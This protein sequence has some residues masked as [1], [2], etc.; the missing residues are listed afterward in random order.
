MYAEGVPVAAKAAPGGGKLRSVPWPQ[1]VGRGRSSAAGAE[2][3]AALY[4]RES[5]L[6]PLGA[7]GAAG[8]P[9]G[10]C[11]RAG[12]EGAAPLGSCGPAPAPV[13]PLRHP[14][15]R[16][17]PVAPLG[18]RGSAMATAALLGPVLF[19][20]FTCI[21]TVQTTDCLHLREQC[22]NA[23]N[24]CESVWNVVEDACNISVLGN[25]CKAEDSVGCNRIIHVLADEYP[26]FRNCVCTTDDICSITTLLGELCSINKDYLESPSGSDPELGVRPPRSPADPGSCSVARRLCREQPRCWAAHRS[27]QRHCRAPAGTCSSPRPASCLLAWK[28]LSTTPLGRCTCP[29]PRRAR[30][31]TIW[32]GIFNNPCLQHSQESQASGAGDSDGSDD[33]DN[34]DLDGEKNLVTDTNNISME[35]KLQWGLSALSKQAHTTNRTCLDVNR[36]CVEDEVCNKQLSL[37]LK[38]C[39]VNKK[40]NVEGCQAAIRFF[41]GNMP[42]EVAQM[43]IFCDC[44]QHDESCYRAKELLH[45]K[46]CAVTVVPP[47]SCLNVIQMC[48]ENELCRKKYTTFRSKC[49]RHVTKKCYND[50]ACLE[51]LLKDDVPCSATAD[52]KAAFVSSW[53]TML[54]TECTCQNVPAVEQPLCELFHHMLH[55][56]SCFRDLRQISIQKKGFHWVNTEM[57]REKISGAQLHSSAINGETVY[58]IA[59]SSCIALILGIVLLTLL[60]I[61]ACRTKHESRRLSSDHSSETFMAH[62]KSHR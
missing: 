35:T 26:E 9:G 50:E 20:Y 54:L 52:C 8:G 31:I 1:E 43:M 48:E 22:I 6:P 28:E 24:G 38:L 16:S 18:T 41:Y 23:G 17:A 58:I 30:C 7:P 4:G 39:S 44:I 3:G 32:K 14:R 25:R 2:A 51:T 33:D 27:F 36:E 59:Y 10:R 5:A 55:S 56:K 13:A 60:K 19:I 12:A 34:A 53:G 15:L 45:G 37:Y 61:R 11:P 57:P 46:P 40:C 47:P 49:W 42:F 29:E 21:S 62:Y